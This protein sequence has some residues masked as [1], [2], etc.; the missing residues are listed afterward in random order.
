MSQFLIQNKNVNHSENKIFMTKDDQDFKHIFKVQ[1]VK[2]GE[3]IK[4]LDE[5]SNQYLAEVT[6]INL[7][8]AFFN[9]LETK[10]F[11]TDSHTVFTLYQCLPKLNKMDSIIE[12][13]IELGV[14]K[15]VPVISSNVIVQL[16]DKSTKHKLNR[17][18]EII[19]SAVKQSENPIIPKI[20]EPIKIES[21]IENQ[22]TKL[23]NLN[24]IGWEKGLNNNLKQILQA[25]YCDKIKNINLLV[26]AE[27]G[28]EKS[29]IDLA[30]KNG[31]Q[32]FRL[33][34]NILRAETAPIVLISI[35]KY[36]LGL[37]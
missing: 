5:L 9:I 17:W 20:S 10:K 37:L 2:I 16:D 12:K 25:K 32:D 1:R 4:F 18:N 7:D 29:E 3:K 34:G 26:G 24:L 35:I 36:E 15:I 33:K 21:I 14:D 23:E 27:G 31:W 6:E 8:L 11:D 13:S 22:N 30:V 19:I 28:F